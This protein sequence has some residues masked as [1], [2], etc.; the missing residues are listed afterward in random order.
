[1][2]YIYLLHVYL[3]TI[4]MS[5]YVYM[6]LSAIAWGLT[7]DMWR[8]MPALTRVS[9]WVN[10]CVYSRVYECAYV[11][12]LKWSSQAFGRVWETVSR[13]LTLGKK[14][15]LHNFIPTI[16]ISVRGIYSVYICIFDNCYSE[17]YH[18]LGAH[19]FYFAWIIFLTLYSW[20]LN[21]IELKK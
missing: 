10:E 11:I 20:W 15:I 21:A 12:T 17:Q 1:M 16:Q 13:E 5:I 3:E 4:H 18:T 19:N 9:M 8:V 7:R 14:K 2:F 6:Y